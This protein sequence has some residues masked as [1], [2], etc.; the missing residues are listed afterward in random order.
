LILCAALGFPTCRFCY[1]QI[2]AFPAQGPAV[3]TCFSAAPVSSEPLI[4]HQFFEL[5]RSSVIDCADILMA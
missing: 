1:W 4:A 3:R 2:R 5:A